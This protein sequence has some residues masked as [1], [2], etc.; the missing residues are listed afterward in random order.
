MKNTCYILS[1]H[2]T[3]VTYLTKCQAKDLV[4]MDKH[5]PKWPWFSQIGHIKWIG[6]SQIEHYDLTLRQMSHTHLM[7]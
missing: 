6:F 2:L 5:P 3:N 7:A 4:K 1:V